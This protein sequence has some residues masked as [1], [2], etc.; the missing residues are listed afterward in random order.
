MAGK[1]RRRVNEMIPRNK[2]ALKSCVEQKKC[3]LFKNAKAHVGD[4]NFFYR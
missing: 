1:V 4:P 2:A 3:N